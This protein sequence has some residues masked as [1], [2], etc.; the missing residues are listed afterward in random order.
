LKE[1][2]TVL[3]VTTPLFDVSRDKGKLFGAFG[4][5]QAQNSLDVLEKAT[6]EPLFVTGIADHSDIAESTVEAQSAQRAWAAQ[7]ATLR[8]DIIRRAAAVLDQ[9]RAEIM[10]WV[11]RETG[12]TKAKGLFEVD[13]SIRETIEASTL[14]T[15]PEGVVLSR[16]AGR[17]SNAVRVPMGVVGIITPWNSPLILAIRAVMP[18][19]ALGNAVLLKP[20]VQTPVCGGFLIAR[21]LEQA[22]LPAGLL[23]VLPGGASTGEALVA[24]DGVDMISFTGS[25]AAGRLVGEA[26]GRLLKRAALELGG[27]NAFIVCSDADL[28][29]ATMAGAFGSFFHQG[30][31]CFTIGRHLVHRDLVEA[32]TTRLAVRAERLRVGDP[33][34]ADVDLGPIVN[35][36]Q[37]ERAQ[38]ILDESVAAG[39]KIISGGKR[40][41]LFFEPTV[42]TNVT[43]DMPLFRE[44]TF[45][46]IAAI[47]PYS[48]DDEAIDLA[49]QTE[50]GLAAAIQSG[51]LQRAR[52][53]AER[54]ATAI[55]HIN[56]Q[57]V[58]HE[59]YGPIGG[60]RASGNGARTGLPAW[61]H[62]F[63][64]WR[65]LTENERSPDYPF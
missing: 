16:H 4:M 54:I 65:W 36:R 27:N 55:V 57:P 3:T 29:R 46:P 63:T 25:S 47:L 20:D 22:G 30:Q 52:S 10:E 44:E 58:V 51:S 38:R 34:R 13:L 2:N 11:I 26:S 39:A 33:F 41:G 32:Y 12:S 56:D 6:G 15:R 64:Q 1:Y 43:P 37:A 24:Q 19:L 45:G 18:A 17:A 7:P 23:Q 21:A 42:V 5:R 50:F 48:T 28:E 62:E 14:A 35:L 59:V 53:M 31:I 9:N 8:S 49:N 40:N 61:E 60:M